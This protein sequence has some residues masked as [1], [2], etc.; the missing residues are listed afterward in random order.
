[1]LRLV[2]GIYFNNEL[3]GILTFSKPRF[4]KEFE[5]ELIRLAWKFDTVVIGGTEK[6]FHK[7]IVDYNP[8]SIISYCDI[9]KFTG[10]VYYK[11]GFK[12]SAK[13]KTKPNYVWVNIKGDVLTRYKTMKQS[14]ID[15]GLGKLGDTEDEIMTALGYFKIYDCGNLKFYWTRDS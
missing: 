12:T 8:N 3:L 7:F 4:N 10:A 9:S 11:I 15:N 14:L 2:Y 13:D 1:M 6:L 5:Y